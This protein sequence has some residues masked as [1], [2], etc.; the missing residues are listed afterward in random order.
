MA[1]PFAVLQPRVRAALVAYSPLTAIVSTRVYDRV[2]DSPTFP[3]LTLDITDA[4][5]NDDDCGKHWTFNVEVHVW[6]REPGR[7]QASIIAGHIRAAM[8]AMTVPAG[9]AFNWN[10]YRSTRMMTDR[11]GLTTHGIITFETGLAATA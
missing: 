1:D 3:Y 4:V 5:E 7:Q 2:P 9:Y 11:D 8:D 10:Q 6:S